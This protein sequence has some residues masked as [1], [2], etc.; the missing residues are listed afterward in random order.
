MVSNEI[1]TIDTTISILKCFVQMK[2]KYERTRRTVQK[3]YF[4]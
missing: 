4:L 2:Q 1:E 3:A